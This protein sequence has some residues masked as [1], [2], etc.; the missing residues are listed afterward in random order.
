MEPVHL[1]AGLG[2]PGVEYACTR[3]NAGFI[4]V[5]KLAQRWD[6][7][8]RISRKLNAHLARARYG[9]RLVVLCK[10]QTFMNASGQALKAAVDYFNVPLDRL[11]VVCDDADL[12]L[13]QLRLRPHGSSGGH[14]GLESVIEHFG[15][16]QFPRLRIGI[17]R[18]QGAREITDYVLGRFTPEETVL[19]GKVLSAACAQLECW[20]DSGIDKAMSKFNGVVVNTIQPEAKPH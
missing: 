20:L 12:P 17:G 18:H 11:V 13:G 4:L 10:P 7:R 14:H 19:L 9:G 8:W 5:D 16:R 1:I 2:N 15:T 3:H 6:E